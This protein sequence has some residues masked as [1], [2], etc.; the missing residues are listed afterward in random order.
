M[1]S[2]APFD[3]IGLDICMRGQ[4]VD[5][6]NR[7]KFYENRSKGFRATGPR[8]TAFPIESVHR[9]YNSVGTTVPHCD[10]ERCQPCEMNDILTR[11]PVWT[12]L[13]SFSPRLFTSPTFFLL[14]RPQFLCCCCFNAASSCVAVMQ[15]DG[16]TAE[17]RVAA[18]L[19]C[20]WTGNWC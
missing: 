8:K 13:K 9:P 5:V 15:R 17:R 6:I 3:R 12:R 19:Q 7:T 10:Q 11:S 2:Y 14:F 18:Q 20:S 4:V 16:S 1:R